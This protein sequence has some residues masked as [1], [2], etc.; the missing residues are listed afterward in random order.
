MDLK[1]SPQQVCIA[2][3]SFANW[4]MRNR[5]GAWPRGQRE[6]QHAH[7]SHY[8][9]GGAADTN[10]VTGVASNG[11]GTDTNVTTPTGANGTPASVGPPNSN[12][13][14]DIM[15]SASSGPCKPQ[16]KPR[17][18][19]FL[20]SA[21]CG[22]PH[23]RLEVARIGERVMVGF[24]WAQRWKQQLK[25]SA[26]HVHDCAVLQPETQSNAGISAWR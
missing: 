26:T 17:V 24:E 5:W 23:G 14:T 7:R 16:H 1:Q 11:D 10:D 21:V 19:T 6:Y 22:K 8:Q 15:Y 2:T 20:R 25:P 3:R 12:T 4:R 18:T 13:A 9:F